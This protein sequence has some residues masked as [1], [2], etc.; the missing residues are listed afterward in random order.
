MDFVGAIRASCC[1][2]HLLMRDQQQEGKPQP[3]YLSIL[4]SSERKSSPQEG[5]G[6]RAERGRTHSSEAVIWFMKAVLMVW[7]FGNRA[8]VTHM[9][10]V[11]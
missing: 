1:H 6:E 10:T 2:A 9:P 5:A 7:P 4:H 11:S 3:G 8:A